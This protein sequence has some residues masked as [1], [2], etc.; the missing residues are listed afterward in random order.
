M[1]QPHDHGAGR[2]LARPQ[3]TTSNQTD[4]KSWPRINLSSIQ[5]AR[6][7][8]TVLNPTESRLFSDS[9]DEKFADRA[10]L[11]PVRYFSS[12]GSLVLPAIWRRRNR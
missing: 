1:V 7:T 9:I 11:S 8:L 4:Y 5:S 6:T 3:R 12:V 2:A 10:R